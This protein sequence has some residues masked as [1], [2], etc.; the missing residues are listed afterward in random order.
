MEERVGRGRR[1]VEEN[2][3]VM[4]AENTLL[5][6]KMCNKCVSIERSKHFTTAVNLHKCD[7]PLFLLSFSYV[8]LL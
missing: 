4:K 8:L 5:L 3:I 6:D 1:E 2:A 7:D